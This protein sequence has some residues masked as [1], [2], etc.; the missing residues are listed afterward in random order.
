MPGACR[1][2]G[3][4]GREEGGSRPHALCGGAGGTAEGG[5]TGSLLCAPCTLSLTRRRRS[6]SL[7][8]RRAAAPQVRGVPRRLN[9][10]ASDPGAVLRLL[11]RE[12]WRQEPE[13][14]HTALQ[15][16]AR[17]ARP[18]GSLRGPITCGVDSSP[19]Q[20][21]AGRACPGVSV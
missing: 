8:A 12:G 18:R 1:L 13:L 17:C 7:P 5:D 4:S 14:P 10:C 20:D 16:Q 19:G 9:S 11:P 6:V 2:Q 3:P 21:A 15:A